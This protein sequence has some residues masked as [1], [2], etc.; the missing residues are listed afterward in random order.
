MGFIVKQPLETN[1]GLLTEAYVRIEMYR[2]DMFYGLL[3]TTIAMYPS[4]QAALE[5]FPVYFGEVNPHPSQIVGVSIVYNDQE[6]QYPT[7]FEIPL[8]KDQEIEVP[9]FEDVLETKTSTYYDFDDNGDIVEKT[10]EDQVTR[11]VQTGTQTIVKQKIDIN[12]NNGN[13]YSFA[14]EQ[15]KKEFGAIFGDENIIDE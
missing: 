14:Y 6:I 11:T 3:H 8:V 15:I 12:K 2:V 7:Y 13:I 9:V 10:R 5:T 4:R 1:Q